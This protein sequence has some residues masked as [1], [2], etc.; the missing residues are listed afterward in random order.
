MHQLLP[1]RCH[2]HKLRAIIYNVRGYCRLVAAAA[3]V[4]SSALVTAAA[5]TVSFV[6]AWSLRGSVLGRRC[7]VNLRACNAWPLS[8]AIAPPA[9]SASC[10]LVH[11]RIYQG[12]WQLAAAAGACIWLT[13]LLLLHLPVYAREPDTPSL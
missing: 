11:A 5:G 9:R 2:R 6:R 10:C 1:L 4:A 12:V 13:K 8:L 3:T 7:C